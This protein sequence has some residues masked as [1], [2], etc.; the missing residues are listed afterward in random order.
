MLGRAAG[1]GG[2]NRAYGILRLV[3]GKSLGPRGFRK[4]PPK[5]SRLGKIPAEG[6]QQPRAGEYRHPSVDVFVLSPGSPPRIQLGIWGGGTHTSETR[7]RSRR[8]GELSPLIFFLSPPS[9]FPGLD[10]RHWLGQ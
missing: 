8:E 6:E 3:A 4:L 7:W 1:G 2:F 9:F 5:S 10:S